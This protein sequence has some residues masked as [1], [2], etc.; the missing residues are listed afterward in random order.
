MPPPL[1]RIGRV[2]L[3]ARFALRDLLRRPLVLPLL[4]LIPALFH[5]VVLATTRSRPVDV[6]IAVLR[7]DGA[8]EPGANPF[9]EDL[10]DDGLRRLDARS[11][12]LVFLGLAASGFLSAFVAFYLAHGRIGVDRRLALAGFRAGDLAAAKLVVLLVLVFVL[13][14]YETGLVWT[15]GEARRPLGLFLALGAGALVYGC[16]GLAL[17]A[18]VRHEL[19]GILVLVLLANIDIGW[20]QNPAYYAKSAGRW[21][22]ESLPGFWPTQAAVVLA[23]T[24]ADFGAVAAPLAA[25]VT[26]AVA[27]AFLALRLRLR[28]AAPGGEIGRR[29][30]AAL[31]AYAL[32]L[33]GFEAV[34]WYARTLPTFDLSM[35]IDAW[36]PFWPNWV[37]I[38]E[39][40]YVLPFAA[41]FAIED[42]HRVNRALVAIG[43]AS[44]AA[45]VVYLGL[46]VAFP[47]PPLGESLAEQ[48]LAVERRCGFPPGANHLPSL[49][50][51]NAFI[52]YCAVRGQRLGRWGDRLAL[53]LAIGIALSTLF[54]KQ[55][56]F[57]DA[58]G[59]MLWG[60]GAWWLAGRAYAS[61]VDPVAP[62][63]VALA[64][65]LDP[66][67]WRTAATRWLVH[68]RTRG[69]RRRAL[70][71]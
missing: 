14:V 50:V 41:L 6:M 18:L 13:A 47:W 58:A 65:A 35:S 45:Y 48:V 42:G 23:L 43:L 44:V 34:G 69:D 24:D 31:V 54:V 53:A 28:P 52:L 1:E 5:A 49:H 67:R 7:E 12:A 27:T 37:W 29:L 15:L 55:H 26:G 9:F 60:F 62:A 36:I 40:T 68:G 61:L 22:I 66:G 56:I 2:A 64:Q 38:Y 70:D 30:V 39:L 3:A 63:G 33:A 20:L 17:G 57:V 10:F 32:W 8:L 71:A 51:A 21:L 16:I 4:F 59:G 25:L 46:P 19:Q 11:L